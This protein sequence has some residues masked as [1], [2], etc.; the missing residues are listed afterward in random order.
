MRK[1]TLLLLAAALL[2]ACTTASKYQTTAQSE[3]NALTKSA[4][5]KMPKVPVPSF[6]NRTAQTKRV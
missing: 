4:S 5:F 6:P 3:I 2:G 1:I